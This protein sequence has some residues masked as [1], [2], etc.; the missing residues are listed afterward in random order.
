MLEEPANAIGPTGQ[1]AVELIGARP[2]LRRCGTARCLR[3]FPLRPDR[4][5]AGARAA[6]AVAA[7]IGVEPLQPIKLQIGA[8]SVTGPGRHRT[9]AVGRSGRSP[10]ARSRSRRWPMRRS[11]RVCGVA[12]R[13]SSSRRY[14]G[15]SVEVRAGLLSAGG[16]SSE[17]RAGG[18]RCDALQGRRGA[19]QP[20]RE[21]VRRDQRA[22]RLPVRAQRD[23]ADAAAAPGLDRGACARNGATRMDTVKALLFDALVL[24]APGLAARAGAGG[25][26]LARRVSHR[27]P[28]ICRLRSRSARSGSSPGRASRSPSAAG[29]L[30][31]CRRRADP[32]AGDLAR[33]PRGRA[34]RVLEAFTTGWPPVRG[35]LAVGLPALR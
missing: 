9:A 27:T 35:S 4:S 32:P 19:G 34:P 24:G 5:P 23:A 18:L 1:R 33:A 11:S 17:R 12:S 26:A 22:R 28:A 10:T 6:C 16:G 13:A 30:A 29:L 25:A 14:P 21:P 3:A 20:G 31:A 2:T 7:G 15:T 8:S